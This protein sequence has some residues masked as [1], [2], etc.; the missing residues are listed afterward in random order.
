[1]VIPALSKPF[2]NS[3]PSADHFNSSL[4]ELEGKKW[5]DQA[6]N[7]IFIQMLSFREIQ[8]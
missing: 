5:S 8:D 3:I 2:I 6:Q 7:R 4:Y 1:M